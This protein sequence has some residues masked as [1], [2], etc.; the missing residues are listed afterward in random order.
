M[1]KLPKHLASK[2]A[3]PY[4]REMYLRFAEE[5]GDRSASSLKKALIQD[6]GAWSLFCAL[7][8]TISLPAT[9]NSVIH[10]HVFDTLVNFMFLSLLSISSGC[11]LI[12][13]RISLLTHVTLSGVPDDDIVFYMLA[14]FRTFDGGYFNF[15]LNHYSVWVDWSISTLLL[16]VACGVYLNSGF[17]FS[18]VCVLIGYVT[19][20][21]YYDAGGV[22]GGTIEEMTRMK[23]ELQ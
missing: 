11:S 8:L 12:A 23:K 21:L 7:M 18:G 13:I 16:A 10:E 15:S 9:L 22:V 17:L 19:V 6:V 20:K 2:I 14:K 1:S 5:G 4:F 3:H